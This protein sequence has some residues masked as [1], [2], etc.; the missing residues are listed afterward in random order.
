MS[1][2]SFSEDQIK[3]DE[4]EAPSAPEKTFRGIHF[5]MYNLLKPFRSGRANRN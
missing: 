5:A 4:S 3:F 1:S 2:G